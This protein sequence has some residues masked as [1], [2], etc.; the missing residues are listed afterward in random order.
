[1]TTAEDETGIFWQGLA[2]TNFV[3]DELSKPYSLTP[4]VK[5]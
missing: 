3:G 2:V 1:M 5:G 4:L